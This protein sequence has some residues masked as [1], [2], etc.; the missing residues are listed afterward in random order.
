M[1]G[2]VAGEEG[3]GALRRSPEW[4]RGW[5]GLVGALVDENV[6]GVMC[7]DRG[8][9]IVWS[10]G[11]A[12]KLLGK[13]GNVYNLKR[14]LNAAMPENSAAVDLFLEA[15]LDGSLLDGAGASVVVGEWPDRRPL[16]VHR[17]RVV[18]EAAVRGPAAV[19]VIVDSWRRL[20]VSSEVVRQTLG[21]TPAESRVAAA[22]AEGLSVREIARANGIR[23]NSV[24]WLV[25]QCFAKTRCRRQADLVRLVL[26]ASRLPLA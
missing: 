22:L 23:R 11:R 16:V 13:A 10:N 21:L 5:G 3:S 26:S 20:S 8:G 4:L 7:V 6:V 9:R 24:R 1:P 14:R 12:R 15:V 17:R 18:G 25:K 2:R 19:L